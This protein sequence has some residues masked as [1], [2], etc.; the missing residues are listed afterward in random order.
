MSGYTIRPTLKLIKAGYAVVVL[1]VLLAFV[2][3]DR[4][5]TTQSVLLPALALLLLAW[6]ASRHA[7]RGFTRMTLTGDKLRYE[8]GFL[9][10]TTRTLQ[11]SKIQNVRVD[12]SITQRL[13][14]TGDI[15]IETAGETS[16]LTMRDVDGPQKVADSIMDAAH[17]GFLPNT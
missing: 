13:L 9:S 12:Q 6:P 2:I 5:A 1:L 3:Y 7:R 15:S 16:G 11:L 14:S 4:Y 10:R 17:R 8:Y